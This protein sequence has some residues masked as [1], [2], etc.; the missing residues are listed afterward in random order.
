MAAITTTVNAVVSGNTV[1]LSG[2]CSWDRCEDDKNS[3]RWIGWA[4]TGT[5]PSYSG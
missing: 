3:D 1:T 5:S 2:T 4:T